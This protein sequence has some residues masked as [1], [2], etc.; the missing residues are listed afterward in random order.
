VLDF[1]TE[2]P[3]SLAD[4]CK[5]VPPARSGKRTHIGTVLRWILDGAKGP[6]GEQVRLEALRIGNRWM[7]S[8]QAIQRFAEAL[9]PRL[10]DS[11]PPVPRTPTARSRAAARAA[12]E[13]EKAGI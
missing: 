13:L 9:T 2:T 6:S 3:I 1:T 7:T 12:R 4:A 10:S 5:L 11:R 8:R